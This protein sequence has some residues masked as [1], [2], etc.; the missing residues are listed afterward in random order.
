MHSLIIFK[1]RLELM[2]QISFEIDD[3]FLLDAVV[4]ICYS[5][6]FR[7]WLS[8]FNLYLRTRG[9]PCERWRDLMVAGDSFTYLGWRLRQEKGGD[10]GILLVFF[11][12]EPECCFSAA[13]KT[14]RC[15][16]F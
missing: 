5:L 12:V 7:E 9:A 13:Q 10:V 8:S 3:V 4:P 14:R 1:L 2:D 15:L 16:F 6:F 11:C